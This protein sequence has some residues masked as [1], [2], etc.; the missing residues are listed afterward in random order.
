M[1][2]RICLCVLFLQSLLM[3]GAMAAEGMTM[4]CAKPSCGFKSMVVFGGGMMVGQLMGYCRSCKKFVSLTWARENA[5]PEMLKD[6]KLEPKPKSLGE[7]WDAKTGNMLKL[8]PCPA[9]KGPF[10]EIRSP[11]QLKH[12]P[13]CNAE[14]FAADGNEPRLMID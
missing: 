6:L 5:P 9:C 1:K 10:A 8:Y 3:V 7:V 11:D 2:A 14:G 13:A 12:C 4:K